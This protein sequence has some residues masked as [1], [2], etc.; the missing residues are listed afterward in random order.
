MVG[1]LLAV[2]AAGAVWD[3]RSG[4]VPNALTYTAAAAGLALNALVR[5]SGIGLG[6][7]ALGLLVGFAPLFI[8]V[9]HP[10]SREDPR[11]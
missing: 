10:L 7:A 1:M 9:K 5:P 8:W 3:V 2:T 4:R 6:Q 11:P